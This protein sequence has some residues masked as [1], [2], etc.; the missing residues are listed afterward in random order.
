MWKSS[1]NAVLFDANPI[2]T[3]SPLGPKVFF[4]Y[5]M[6]E[7]VSRRSITLN[8]P[9]YKQSKL[10]KS[11]SLCISW[12]SLTPVNLPWGGVNRSLD[13]QGLHNWGSCVIKRW[14]SHS[15][16]SQVYHLTCTLL[17]V[18]SDDSQLFAESRRGTWK[19]WYLCLTMP[20]IHACTSCYFYSVLLLL[21]RE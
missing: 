12:P 21:T 20:L 5:N 2:I 17:Q 11:C 7:N 1:N 10:W 16:L 9:L 14:L 18:I 13:M 3:W 6:C 8:I 15:C 19:M 4:Q